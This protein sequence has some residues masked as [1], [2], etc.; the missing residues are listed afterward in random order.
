MVS[1]NNAGISVESTHTRP[2]AIHETSEEDWD[3]T[4]AINVKGVFLGCK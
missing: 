3:K 1:R 2:H 4:M